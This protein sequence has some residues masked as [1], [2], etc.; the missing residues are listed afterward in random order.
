M[1]QIWRGG[2]SIIIFI[3]KQK[4]HKNIIDKNIRKT[5]LHTYGISITFLLSLFT[6][7][8]PIINKLKAEGG[9]QNETVNVPPRFIDLKLQNFPNT[10]SF[11]ISTML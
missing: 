9:H 7:H 2:S 8:Y 11:H 4:G 3:I 1:P 6:Y 10:S 5:N